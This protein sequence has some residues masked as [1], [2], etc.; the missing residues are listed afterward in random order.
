LPVIRRSTQPT[1]GI[2]L[3]RGPAL[4]LGTVLLVAGLFFLY[5]ESNFTHFSNIPSGHARI[6]GKA[7][8]G[9]FGVNGWSGEL[10][11]AA[12]GLLLLGAAQHL[13]AKTASL[14]VGIAFAGVAIIA[15]A[16][17]HSA[18]G[19]FAANIWTIVLW[20]ASAALL[21]LNTLLP[22]TASSRPVVVSQP[23]VTPLP[24]APVTASEPAASHEPAA[25]DEI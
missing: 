3:S 14:V 1:P 8:F 20:G 11:A 25:T 10:T 19:L 9:I 15:L 13:R 18:L 6:G 16:D 21:L 23:A 2:S 12:G 5:R 7:F 22:R 24:T 17:H 4:I